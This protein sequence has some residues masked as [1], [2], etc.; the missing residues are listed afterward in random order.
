VALIEEK[1]ADAVRYWASTSRLG[2]DTAFSEDLLKIGKKLVNK[3]WNA[4]K[5]ASA[6]LGAIKE[7][8]G[9]AAQ[10]A[11][12]G[13]ITEPL[14]LWILTRL[15]R[16]IAKATAEFE[17][18]EY[19]DARAAIEDFFWNDFCDNYL[20]MVK[21][22]AYGADDGWRMTDDEKGMAASSV[23]RHPSSESAH[24]ALYHCLSAILR[25]FAPFVPHITEE[26]YSHIFAGEF[27]E[28]GSIHARGNWPKYID[29]PVS[30]PEEQAGIDAVAILNEVRKIKAERN[31][32]MKTTID[33]L[34]I[35]IPEE[36]AALKKLQF[37]LQSVTNA[38]EIIWA[39]GDSI[40]VSAK[41]SPAA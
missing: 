17:K 23:I 3:I 11:A 13:I 34:V 24:C 21:V 18:F 10:D 14:D 12:S 28:S 35:N 25:L 27:K 7:K 1:G 16:A 29:Y 37:D 38:K 22:R 4:S 15:H 8:P 32:S 33:E 9:T 40:A 6:H 20:E 26:I 31:L 5:F 41:L 19:C 30:E 2:S 36:K 39:H